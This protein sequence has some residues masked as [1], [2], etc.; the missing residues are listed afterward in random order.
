MPVVLLN[1]WE[2]RRVGYQSQERLLAE[3]EFSE[4]EQYIL[5]LKKNFY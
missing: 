3:S 1:M 5:Y 4:Y 2:S